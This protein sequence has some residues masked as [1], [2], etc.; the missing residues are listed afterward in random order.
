MLQRSEVG[1]DE[2]MPA[3]ASAT[4]A[5]RFLS[6]LTRHRQERPRALPI[7]FRPIADVIVGDRTPLISTSQASRRALAAVDK[8]AATT[9]DVIHLAQAPSSTSEM[10]AVIAHELTHVAS[11][12]P[13]P[14]FFDDDRHS[15]EERRAT[16]IGNLMRR[17]P[18]LSN[19]AAATATTLPGS[20]IM[21]TPAPAAPALSRDRTPT[22]RREASGVVEESPGP[23]RDLIAKFERPSSG[24]SQHTTEGGGSSMP[25]HNVDDSGPHA[26]IDPADFTRNLRQNFDLIVELLEDRIIADLERRGGRFKGDF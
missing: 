10:H 5:D 21:Q 16:E 9:G 13:A 24:G 20:T 14:R 3:P 15:P 11:P 2:A 1:V 25:Q 18:I 17:A 7:Q 23:I 22:I 8:V 12:S 6:E 4:L 19:M 26:W